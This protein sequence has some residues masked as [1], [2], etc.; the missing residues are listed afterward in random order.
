VSFERFDRRRDCRDIA[1]AAT[2]N[3]CFEH[4]WRTNTHE[5]NRECTRSVRKASAQAQLVC[6]ANEI[7]YKLSS[8]LLP[9]PHKR[10]KRRTHL[11]EKS[12]T[13]HPKSENR[14]P[15]QLFG[16][17]LWNSH[18]YFFHNMVLADDNLVAA[19]TL[20]KG[21]CKP[22]FASGLK[23]TIGG[24][25]HDK[26]GSGRVGVDCDSGAVLLEHL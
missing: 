6:S 11:S 9:A 17:A 13:E 15:I 8:N 1:H 21:R 4:L 2:C 5:D 18:R 12:F 20:L 10:S 3:G 19:G 7:T 22:L 24:S 23:L 25:L 26:K 16:D 14:S